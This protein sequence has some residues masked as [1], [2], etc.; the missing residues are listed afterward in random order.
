MEL[1]LSNHMEPW[2]DIEREKEERRNG[3]R[4]VGN[5]FETAQVVMIK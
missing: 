1:F 3:G 5:V 2:L 4:S